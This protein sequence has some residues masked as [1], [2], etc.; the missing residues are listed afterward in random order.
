MT[1]DSLTSQPSALKLIET[2]ILCFDSI[3]SNY[4][5]TMFDSFSSNYLSTIFFCRFFFDFSLTYIGAGMICSHIVNISLILGAVLSWGIMWPSIKNL[6]GDWFPANIPENSMKSLQGYKVWII[7]SCLRIWF[8]WIFHEKQFIS[9]KVT[10]FQVFLSIALILGDGLYNFAKI[11]FITLSSMLSRYKQK[12]SKTGKLNDTD[13][14]KLEQFIL[15]PAAY[16]ST[17]CSSYRW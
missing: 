5:F 1:V 13:L 3:I 9:Y 16:S 15:F 8:A 2:R 7:I 10:I 6:E 17:Y 12:K 14:K 4:S 11:M